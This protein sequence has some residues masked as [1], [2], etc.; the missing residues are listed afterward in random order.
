MRCPL[1]PL[2]HTFSPPPLP[3][4]ALHCPPCNPSPPPFPL[5]QAAPIFD[6]KGIETVRRD[7]CPAVAKMMEAVLRLL[8]TTKDLSQVKAYCQRQWGKI[9]AGRV[10]VADFVFAKEVSR[11]S[12][13]AAGLSLG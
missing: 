1:H 12:M 3:P 9:M 4:H 13:G 2:Q 6:A 7:T 5:R 8:F 11:H 10:S